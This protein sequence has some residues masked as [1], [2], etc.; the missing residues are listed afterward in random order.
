MT[1]ETKYN[2]GDEVW[3][4]CENKAQQS[5]IVDIR[6]KCEK[7]DAEDL[8]NDCPHPPIVKDGITIEV[9]YWVKKLNVACKADWLYREQ[10]LFPTKEE[11]IKSL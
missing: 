11:L 1:I 2:I 6:V 7:E 8:F 4:M 9:F 10:N 5:Y 3:F